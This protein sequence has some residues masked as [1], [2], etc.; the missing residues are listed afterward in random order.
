MGIPK[1]IPAWGYSLFL[2]ARCVTRSFE[3]SVAFCTPRLPAFFSLP[4]P[5]SPSRARVGL[6]R[7]TADSRSHDTGSRLGARVLK[8][9]EQTTADAVTN[10]TQRVGGEDENWK[11][12]SLAATATEPR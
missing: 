3:N 10:L 9:T 8:D 1:S 4:N 6:V 2:L 7:L 12:P 11:Q 5:P